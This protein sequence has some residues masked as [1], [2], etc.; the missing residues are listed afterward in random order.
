MFDYLIGT[1]TNN[2]FESITLE[3]NNIGYKIYVTKPY[4]FDFRE[5]KIFL[6]NHIRESENS[7]YGFTDE[8]ERKIFLKLINIKGIGPKIVLPILATST[9]DEIKDEIENENIGYLIKFPK[10]GEK[11]A[12][13]MILDL[14]GK[15]VSKEEKNKVSDDLILALKSLGYKAGNINKVIKEIDCDLKIEEQIKSAL[16]MLVK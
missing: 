11:I 3:V 10:I 7:L 14:R 16:K 8:E 6:Y 2:N 5:H 12:R 4:S 9:V 1:V 15:L 13:Q